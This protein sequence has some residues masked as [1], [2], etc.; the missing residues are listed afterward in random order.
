MVQPRATVIP[1]ADRGAN[2]PRVGRSGEPHTDP[3]KG[4]EPFLA[5]FTN[6]LVQSGIKERLIE[7]NA[8]SEQRRGTIN[9]RQLGIFANQVRG[10]LP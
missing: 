7:H 4:L 6:P 10:A 3:F 8:F 5:K 1:M 2:V 9:T